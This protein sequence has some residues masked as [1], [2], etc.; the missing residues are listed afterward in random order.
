MLLNVGFMGLTVCPILK[1]VHLKKQWPSLLNDY[2]T[3][4]WLRVY[5]PRS[6]PSTVFYSAVFSRTSRH[7]SRNQS[8]EVELAPV[9]PLLVSNCVIVFDDFAT[10]SF[11][12]SEVIFLWE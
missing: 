5:P 6:N 8:L 12:K 3:C 7:G 2:L 10:L 1:A 11:V 9:R 4:L